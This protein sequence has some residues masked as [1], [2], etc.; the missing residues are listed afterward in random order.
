MVF[1]F[2][3]E[4]NGTICDTFTNDIV[5]FDGLDENILTGIDLSM[6]NEFESIGLISINSNGYRKTIAE[7]DRVLISD[8]D[9]TECIRLKNNSIDIGNVVL[10]RAGK[11]ISEL[12]EPKTAFGYH[13]LIKRYY[14]NRGY[15]FEKT[16]ILIRLPTKRNCSGITFEYIKNENT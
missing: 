7:A 1:A 8:G 15:L 16:N 14:T 3:K 9:F 4:R 10:T 12:I 2:L 6:L 11:Y 5:F 13:D